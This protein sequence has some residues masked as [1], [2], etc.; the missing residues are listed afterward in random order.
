VA[1]GLPLWGF[2]FDQYAALV[3]LGLISHVAG[4]LCINYALGHLR[5]SLTSVSLLAQPVIT[6]VASVP[7]LG[8]ALSVA[9]V[10]GGALVLGGIYLANRRPA[11]EAS[12]EPTGSGEPAT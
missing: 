9:Q 11:S 5:A 2:T 10:A 3:A 1:T 6:A 12:A 8:E 7:L 4:W